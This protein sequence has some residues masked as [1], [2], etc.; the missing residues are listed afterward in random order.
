MAFFR[1]A[2]AK[3]RQISELPKLFEEKF[4]E[5]FYRHRFTTFSLLQY[6]LIPFLSRKRVQN[7]C[8]TTYPPNLCTK[9]FHTFLQIADSQRTFGEKIFKTGKRRWRVHLNIFTRAYAH[10]YT[11][12]FAPEPFTLFTGYFLARAAWLFISFARTKETK[13]RKFAVC[14]FL[15][16]PALFSAKQKELASLK[17]L[18]VFN[19]PKST[20]ASRQKSEAGPVRFGATLLRSLKLYVFF[21]SLV[22][23]WCFVSLRFY[24][25]SS[26]AKRRISWRYSVVLLLRMLF[27]V[28][29]SL[30]PLL[31]SRR[32]LRRKD[33]NIHSCCVCLIP[34]AKCS[35][36][37]SLHSVPLWMTI[38]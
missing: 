22:A 29:I 34:L 31:S 13:Q 21:V 20:S 24:I 12:N 7:Y 5:S 16:T 19:A 33:H 26:R 3:V 8:F 28:V 18:F 10:V 17:Q 25:L 37:P 36:D 14:T 35:R 30:I 38:V 9:F 15:P 23:R 32:L 1:K 27:L 2:D 4:S 6:Q 11:Y